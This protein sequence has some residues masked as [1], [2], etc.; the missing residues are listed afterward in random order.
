MPSARATTLAQGFSAR[1]MREV[2]DRSLLDYVV[3]RDYEGEVNSVGSKLNILNIARLSEKTYSGSNLAADSLY[4][5]NAVLTID[6]WKSFYWNEKTIDNWQSYIKNPH[7]T[8]VSQ[9]ADE[10]SRNMD[11]YAFG[12]YG[13]VASGNRVGTDYTTGTVTVTTS[14]GAV[15][16]SGTTFTSAMVGKGFKAT[17]HTKWYRVK[18]YTSA[19]SIVIED[20][21][22]DV[23]SAYTGGAIGAGASYTIEA[24][25]PVQI[26]TSNL[27][28]KISALKLKLDQAEINGKSSVPDSDRW[29]VVPPEFET[30]LVQSS[31]I[32]LAVPSAYEDLIKKGMIGMLQGFK[33]FKSTRLTGD[34][35]NGY[36]VLAGH[37]NWLT[38]AEKVLEV[39]VE[40]D[41]IANFGSAY[42][43]LFVYGGKVT[44]TRRHFAAE[45]FF[46]FNV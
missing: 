36:H 7:S 24:A 1:L 20:D 5:N 4:E 28:A 10:R 13:K 8:V 15:T 6:Q 43:D 31:N 21:L 16:G 37:P 18:T 34:N 9:K 41:L 44:D 46:T 12:L 26:T 25:T 19:T 33:V 29:L 2:Y 17:G 22:D 23:T 38:F 42:K 14:T 11:L 30:L 3:N 32:V 39:G 40:E 35:T 45:G 27:L